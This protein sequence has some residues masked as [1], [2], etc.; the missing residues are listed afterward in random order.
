MRRSAGVVVP[1]G[2]FVAQRLY[3]LLA[4]GAL[5][6]DTGIGR[7]VR[8]LGPVAFPIAAPREVAFDVIAAPYLGRTP[9]ALQRELQV[10]ER[11]SDMVLAAHFTEVKR[12]TTTTL[13]TVRFRRP[14]RIDF[15]LVRGP[16]PHVVESFL[17]EPGD[18]GTTLT[19]RGELGS[20]FWALGAWWGERV[21]RQWEA[22]V[23]RS[24]AA[25][26]VEAERRAA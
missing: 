25:I 4:D 13:E 26:T 6:V 12:G 19:W 15:R 22:A 21:A 23:R 8:P 24:V 9:R 17:L 7:S 5:T 10:W 18:A 14:E 1:V 11:G 20:D 2:F 16:V 3:R